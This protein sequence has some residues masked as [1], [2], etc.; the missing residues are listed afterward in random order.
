MQFGAA[1]NAGS[2][3]TALT[4]SSISAFTVEATS[5]GTA[6]VGVA[7]ETGITARAQNLGVGGFS[8]GDIGTGV[9]GRGFEGVIG[10]SGAARGAGVRGS[11]TNIGVLGRSGGN[12]GSA[13]GVQGIATGLDANGVIGEANNGGVAFGVW[14]KSTQGFAGFFSGKVAVVGNLIKSGGGFKIDHPLDPENRY[15]SHSFVESPMALN[16]YQGNVV[17]GADGSATVTLPDYFDALNR[18]Y[19]YQ[20]TVIGEVAQAIIAEEIT[21]DRFIIR[22]DKPGVKVSWQVTGARRDPFSI[23]YPILVEEEK[24]AEERG[25]YLHPEA[26]GKPDSQGAGYTMEMALTESRAEVLDREGRIPDQPS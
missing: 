21:N 23:Q 6:I 10:E 14:G 17:T 13:A 26:Y 9:L 22:T 12:S 19:C 15:L 1:N 3:G 4:S 8:P 11:A 20:L 25:T 5:I 7:Q 24:P 2:D 16:I 18:D